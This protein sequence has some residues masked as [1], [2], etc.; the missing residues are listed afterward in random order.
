MRHRVTL[1]IATIVAI[2]V[3]TAPLAAVAVLSAQWATQGQRALLEDFAKLT[4]QRGLSTINRAETTLALLN[5]ENWHDCS[6]EHLTRMRQLTIDDR[7]VEEVGF[8]LGGM[9]TCT[10]W[11]PVQELIPRGVPDYVLPTG[12]GLSFDVIPEVTGA[13]TVLVVSS[14]QH[15]ALVKPE[16]FVDV[17]FPAEM[18]I[19]VATVDGRIF[20]ASGPVNRELAS[21]ILTGD[22]TGEYMLAAASG[23]GLEAFAIADQAAIPGW[24]D[25]GRWMLIP[26]SLIVSSVL[27]GLVVL[28]SRQQLSLKSDILRAMHKGEFVA[29]YQPLIELSTGRCVGAEALVRWRRDGR[30]IPPDVFI[31]YA[32]QDDLILELTATVIRRV[33][34]DLGD[35]LAHEPDMHVAVNVSA[36][37]MV[38]GRFIDVLSKATS[39]AGVAPAR[40]WI[41][42]TERG[43]IDVEAARATLERARRAG[44]SVAIDD[45]GTGYS[46]LSLLESLPLDALKIDKSFVDAIG[47]NAASSVVT[48][49]IIEMAHGLKLSIIAEGVE[50]PEQQAYL[51]ASGVE[52]AQGWLFSK[53]LPPQEFLA[54]YRAHKTAENA[55][56]SRVA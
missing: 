16:R 45:F 12:S 10:G 52:Y 47:K 4:L 28:L 3:G 55:A 35:E 39:E 8:Y 40:I 15:R 48:P 30:L 22:Q 34:A 53:A 41:E 17:L 32:E 2:C 11:G 42:A 51:Q 31:P 36:R 33:V 23:Y 18:T 6:P 43:F 20:A 13:G 19:G 24:L 14:G 49:H 38:D 50:T 9:L 46:S 37:D 5:I 56:L 27:V 54:Y 7:S 21:A 44:H 1:V 29:H 25:Q 26:V